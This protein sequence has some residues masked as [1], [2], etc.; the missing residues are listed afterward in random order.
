[1]VEQ[2]RPRETT[3]IHERGGL[4][5]AHWQEAIKWLREWDMRSTAK[6]LAQNLKRSHYGNRKKRNEYVESI[7][8]REG[9]ETV[10]SNEIIAYSQKVINGEFPDNGFHHRRYLGKLHWGQISDMRSY[11]L[12]NELVQEILSYAAFEY[13]YY[14]AV[15]ERPNDPWTRT[16]GMLNNKPL[17]SLRSE[18]SKVTPNQKEDLI[19]EVRQWQ[20][21]YQQHFGIKPFVVYGESFQYLYFVAARDQLEN[22]WIFHENPD[23]MM[24]FGYLDKDH[25]ILDGDTEHSSQLPEVSAAL[26]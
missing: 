12:G 26:Q 3:N 25:V 7:Y 15:Y 8:G 5:Q 24:S 16:F 6:N 13:Y 14:P 21:I 18:R 2:S 17:A 22:E 23:V 4:T 9:R 1:M 11:S 10:T 19:S 20:E